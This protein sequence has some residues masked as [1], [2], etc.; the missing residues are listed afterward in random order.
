[1]EVLGEIDMLQVS[2]VKSE[3]DGGR[4]KRGEK[5]EVENFNY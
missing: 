5:V 4:R 2:D 1:M 3:I